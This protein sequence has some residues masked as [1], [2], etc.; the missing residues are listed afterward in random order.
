MAAAALWSSSGYFS[1]LIHVDTWTMQFWRALSGGTF[2]FVMLAA[3]T[4]WK[5]P[6]ALFDIGR[7]GLLIVPCSALSMVC[8][9]AA[10]HLTTVAEVMIVYATQPFANAA[11]AWIFL[12]E[13]M[14]RRTALAALVALCGVCLTIFG[15]E[16]SG[17]NPYRAFGD[18]VALLMVLGFSAV[19]VGARGGRAQS[20]T[21]INSLAALL[22]ALICLP[23]AAP[24]SASWPDIW[25][26][27][28][29]GSLTLGMGLMLLTAGTR[30]VPAGEAGLMTLLDVPLSP[31]WVWLAFGETPGNAALAGG[32][33]V[34]GAV[35]WQVLGEH[36]GAADAPLLP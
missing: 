9:I 29:F 31:L 32:L 36:H 22:S 16:F 15:G 30:L 24:M 8:Y 3:E 26:L 6:R 35:V 18:G 23:L 21:A 17:A 12:R 2:L 13:P 7:T 25:M 14:G 4:G 11:V 19:F 10:L 27:I 34:F 33:I 20:M 1:R 5:A 28:A